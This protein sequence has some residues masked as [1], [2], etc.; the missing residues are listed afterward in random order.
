MSFPTPMK[1]QGGFWRSSWYDE[2]GKRRWKSFGNVKKVTKGEAERRYEEWLASWVV[3]ERVKNPGRA[4]LTLQ[5]LAE[6][7]QVHAEQYYRRADGTPTRE[8]SNIAYAVAHVTEA[9]GDELASEFTPGKLKAV[10][11]KMIAAG[12]ARTTINDRVKK[13][14]GMFKWAASEELVTAEVW[15]GLQAVEPLKRGRSEAK[16]TE[17]V[18]PAPEADIEKVRPDVPTPVCALIDLQLLTG[19]RPGE[20][21]LMRGCDLDMSGSEWVFEPEWHKTQHHG[22]ERPILLGPRS[23]AIITPYL[24]HD[25]AAYL[26]RSSHHKA[27]LPRY[28]V[29]SYAQAIRRACNRLGVDAWSPGQL[30]HNAGTRLREVYGLEGAKVILGHQKVETTQV[31]AEADTRRARQIVAEVG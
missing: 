4:G 8:A 28:T 11:K 22:H 3:D 20:V 17:K 9:M 18:T 24:V 7:Y 15:H 1:N 13:V 14:R 25:L 6:R 16:E 2:G 30:R 29:D 5:D 31:Y 23:Q 19:M 10:R 26:F 21:V 27:K 12:L